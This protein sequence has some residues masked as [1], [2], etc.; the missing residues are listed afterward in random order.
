LLLDDVRGEIDHRVM[1]AMIVELRHLFVVEGRMLVVVRVE[2]DFRYHSA[3]LAAELGEQAQGL[4]AHSV[5]A[6]R[7][8]H[9]LDGLFFRWHL[10]HDLLLLFRTT[11]TLNS[12]PRLTCFQENEERRRVVYP[13]AFRCAA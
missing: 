2:L 1:V 9:Q 4:G 6:M 8:S 12:A 7:R 3:P 11:V 10:F 13:A 5:Q